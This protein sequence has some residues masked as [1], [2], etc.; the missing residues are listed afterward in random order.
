MADRKLK[1]REI[2]EELKISEGCVFTI[3]HGHLTMR[4]LCSKWV[5]CLLTVDQ[6]QRRID[7]SERCLQLFQRNKKEFCVN[8]T[9]DETW[10]HHFSPESNRQSAEWTAAGESRPELPKMQTSVGKVLASVFWDGQCILFI[11]YLEKGRTINLR[12]LCSIIGVFEGKTRK[13]KKR[14]QMKKKMLFYQDNALRHTSIATMAKVH[15]WHFK[16]ILHPPCSPDLVPSNYS[17][18]ADL[19]KKKK[20]CPRE[21]D[22]AP[23]KK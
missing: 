6:K 8:M 18:F 17:L 4:K 19:K 5:P 3:L 14:P 21:K 10:V 11:D 2:A 22:L 1:L 7:D 9:M 12:I 15:E 23:M 16:L 20:K 13:K